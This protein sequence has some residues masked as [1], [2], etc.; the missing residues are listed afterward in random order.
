MVS[1]SVADFAETLRNSRLLE[2]VQLLELNDLL[3]AHSGDVRALA[4]ELI[5]RGWLTAY[6]VNQIFRG[7]AEE[8]MLGSYVLLERL[9]AGG[10]GEVFKA[11]NWKLGKI[12]ALKLIRSE[13][14]ANADAVRRFQREVRAAALLNYPNIVH[15]FDCD[16]AAGKHFFVMEYVEGVDLAKY[17]KEH[18]PLGVALACACV[19]QAA[20]GLQHAFE[21]G[22]VHRDIKPHNLL[23]TEERDGWQPAERVVKI[24]DMGL[25]R[26]SQAGDPGDSTSTVTEEG[27]LMGT[28]DYIAPEQAL[29]AH[30]ADTRSDLYSLGCTF[31]FLLTGRVPYPG[32]TAAEKLLRH[33]MG[34]PTPVEQLRPGL[35]SRG[36]AIVRKLMAR[37]PEDRYQTPAEAAADLASVLSDPNAIPPLAG[38]PEPALPLDSQAM[39]DTSSG[40]SSLVAQPIAESGSS[41]GLKQKAKRRQ[42][43]WLA[44]AGVVVVLGAIGLL[45]A[46]L[47][48]SKRESEPVAPPVTVEKPRQAEL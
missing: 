7:R 34:Q 47:T 27:T 45:V 36:A 23:L 41:S 43:L 6:Q 29:N 1:A 2:P 20:L 38:Q 32:G 26:L 8:L 21:R 46:L 30:A 40:W 18:G 31:Y 4:G 42:V 35:P 5:R 37:R 15:A 17:V 16:E 11:R 19:R 39:Q 22:L 10:M 14:L 28:L 13:R 24:L 9:G 33:Q 12:V 48:G 44:S 25:A 3:A